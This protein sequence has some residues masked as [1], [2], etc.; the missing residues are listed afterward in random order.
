MLLLLFYFQPAFSTPT[1]PT[2]DF[3]INK[4]GTVTHKTTGLTWMRCAMGQKWTG[5]TCSGS[6][7]I[8]SYDQA[9]VLTRTFA[10]H[11]D[12]RL[13]NIAE[14]H[15]IV[16]RESHSPAINT[17][18]F[19]NTLNDYFWSSSPYAYD[20]ELAWIVHFN[21]GSDYYDY[22]RYN[23][24]AVRLVRGGQPF[25][26]LP[27][28]TPTSDFTD[29]Q[30]GTVTHKRTG[31]IWQRCAIGQLW[32][33]S[34]C[35]GSA[36]T[37]TYD[38]ALALTSTF[39]SY[40][41]W[42]VPNQ[43]ELLSI[44]EYGT[45]SSAINTVPF[46][47]TPDLFWSSSSFTTHT[48]WITH[49][50]NGDVSF[51][52]KS[53]GYTVRLVRGKWFFDSS[54]K[55][56]V[57]Y[58]FLHGLNS[59]PDVWNTITQ[60]IFHGQNECPAISLKTSQETFPK[61]GCYRYKFR[62]NRVNND[63]W[64]NGD[65]ATFASLGSELKI[66]IEK[67]QYAVNPKAIILVGHSR[68]GLAARAYLQSLTEQPSFKLGLLTIGT[69]HLGS[70]F[71]RVK[72]W[73][74]SKGYTTND[75][76]LYSDKLRFIYSPSVGYLATDN[77]SDGKL[78]FSNISSAIWNMNKKNSVKAL[79][80]NVSVFGEIASYGIALGE[81]PI[82]TENVDLFNSVLDLPILP[83][84]INNLKS[85]VFKNITNGWKNNSDGIVPLKSQII[86]GLPYFDLNGKP[87]FTQWVKQVHHI[88]EI[89][90]M[91]GGIESILDKMQQKLSEI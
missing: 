19:P 65:G 13:P 89:D 7:S 6:T 30:N 1:T 34:T 83:G 25:D 45:N 31:L 9:I 28:T 79:V 54:P 78:I 67:I 17:A 21:Y 76:I 51:G 64:A 84:D 26:F 81:Y 88:N 8:Y 70:P 32:T 15:T 56:D 12:W 77:N 69:P 82:G 22:D 73:L 27:F 11:N 2:S 71:G 36:S 59:H 18:L 53:D 52:N 47:N 40:N 20:S 87:I 35:S 57:V 55:N 91:K 24:H 29:N 85:F 23:S 60:E 33:G 39:A 72:H 14:L 38:Q 62:T 50:D 42:R 5:S 4:D 90:E 58:L 48:A 49:F 75:Q 43:N 74:D 80:N 46:P 68:G 66:A 63:I 37:Y 86:A 16:E 10:G 44:V 41:D 3:I 61:T